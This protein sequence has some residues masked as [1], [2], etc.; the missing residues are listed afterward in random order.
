MCVKTKKLIK[1]RV[2]FIFV[3]LVKTLFVWITADKTNIKFIKLLLDK[4]VIVKISFY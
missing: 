2:L 4:K 1:R 3:L